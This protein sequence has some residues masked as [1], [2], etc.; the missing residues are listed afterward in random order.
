MMPYTWD[1][2]DYARAS[3]EQQKWARE[4]IGKLGLKG[5]ERVLDIGCGDGKVTAEIAARVPKGRVTGVDNST[6]MI[7]LARGRHADAVNLEFSIADA[8]ALPFREGF[9]V[10]F[11]NAALHWVR[12]HRPVV[13]GIARC[14]RPGGRALLQMGGRGNAAGILAA[15]DEMIRGNGWRDHFRGCAF[16]YGFHGPEEYEA[17]LNESGL[18]PTR[19]ELIPKDM[20]HPGREGLAGWVRTTWLPYTQ[21][22]PDDRREAFIRELVDRYLADHPLDDSGKAHVDMVRLEVEATRPG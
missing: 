7:Q 9:D 22:V 1:A 19:V 3:S 16:P 20:V 4:L 17:W 15:V 14:L 21:R 10:V 8:R 6:A 11:S 18:R 5:E 13:R 2:E 12:N